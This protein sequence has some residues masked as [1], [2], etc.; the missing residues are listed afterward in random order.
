MPL[1]FLDRDEPLQGGAH[2]T[3]GIAGVKKAIQQFDNATTS[4]HNPASTNTSSKP[5]PKPP[6]A[7]KS[8]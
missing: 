6:R 3:W 2:A 4:N 1:F 5:N 8:T 7:L